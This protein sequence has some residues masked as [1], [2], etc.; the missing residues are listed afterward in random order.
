MFKTK[1]T[2]PSYPKK[3]K[4]MCNTT[5]LY[6]FLA[7]ICFCRA[8]YGTEKLCMSTPYKVPRATITTLHNKPCIFSALCCARQEDALTVYAAPANT[9]KIVSLLDYN[10]RTTA[11]TIPL[12]DIA[13]ITIPYPYAVWY[14]NRR[15]GATQT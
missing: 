3:G 2:A 6:T 11:R 4:T 15:T 12:A 9:K 7:S 5:A 10:P 1:G 14:Y 8:L 13:Q